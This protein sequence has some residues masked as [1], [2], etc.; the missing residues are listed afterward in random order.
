MNRKLGTLLVGVGIVAAT[1]AAVS[2]FAAAQTQKHYQHAMQQLAQWLG[3][4]ADVRTDYQRGFW[5]A[6]ARTT[7][8][9]KAATAEDTPAPRLLIDSTIEH[10]PGAMAQLARAVV[11]T[12]FSLDEL[13]ASTQAAIQGA[14]APTLITLNRYNGASEATFVLPAGELVDDQ[15]VLRWGELRQT[16]TTNAQATQWS[17]TL[18]WPSVKLHAT[19]PGGADTAD[20]TPPATLTLDIQ[21]ISASGDMRIDDGLWLMAP[22]T[23]Q[24][25]LASMQLRSAVEAVPDQGFA[26]ELKNTRLQSSIERTG[27]LL[28]RVATLDTE[29]QIG[30]LS[31]EHLSTKETLER[32][33]AKALLGLQQWLLAAVSSTSEAGDG[34]TQ[35]QPLPALDPQVHTRLLAARPG[36]AVDIRATALGEEGRLDYALTIDGVPAPPLLE[37]KDW[38]RAVLMQHGRMQSAFSLPRRWVREI[39]S[40]TTMFKDPQMLEAS[41]DKL[42]QQGLI[43]LDERSIGASL[44]WGGGMLQING[45]SL[46]WPQQMK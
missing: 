10:G 29:G 28:A 15:D 40:R 18:N 9:W 20:Q 12:R 44:Q 1:G 32:L 27:E 43:T 3:P 34:E 22:G 13:S 36:Y 46:P 24:M 2:W 37:R 30:G 35:A 11:H 33:D 14:S 7:V 41:L 17:T 45:K 16:I 23:A 5:S 19:T 6:R 4:K 26:L 39:A 25:R 8:Q 38:Q 31:L 21:D 42:Q